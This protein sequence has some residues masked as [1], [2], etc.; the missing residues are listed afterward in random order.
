MRGVDVPGEISVV[1]YDDTRLASLSGIELTSVSQDA[2]A[3]AA[4]AIRSAIARAEGGVGPGAEFVT[5]PRLV[6]RSTSG[7]RRS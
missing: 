4:A 2:S 5:P 1:G 3:L 6:L 7:P